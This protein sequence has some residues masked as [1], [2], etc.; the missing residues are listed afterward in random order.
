MTRFS[1]LSLA[2]NAL[3][4]HR[5]WQRTWR[6]ASPRETYDVVIVGGGGHGLATAYY[7]AKEHGISNVAVLEKGL[8][9]RRQCRAQHHHHPLE[10][11]ARRQHPVLR[12]VDEAVGG[13]RAGPQLQRDGQPARR[14]QPLSLRRAA[15]RL[16]AARQCHAAARRRCRAARPRGRAQAWRPS[17]ISTTRAFRSW[18]GCCSA[19]AARCATT[20]WPGAMRAP[21]IRARRRHHPELRG[22]RSF[23]IERRRAS[24]ASRRRAASSGARKVGARRRRQFVARRGDG[25]PAAADRKPCAAGLRLRGR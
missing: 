4:G 9:R 16:R 11:P 8:D 5:Q 22:D 19:A 17:S 1:I 21:P 25:G 18:A 13:P 15:R 14:A 3:S 24:S 2:R 7:L 6:D 12:M 23:A 10:L 20:R